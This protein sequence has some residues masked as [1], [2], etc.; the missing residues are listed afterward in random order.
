MSTKHQPVTIKLKGGMGNQMFQF[1]FGQ[2]LKA[3]AKAHG[4]DISL[5]FDISAYID[6][7]KKDTVRPY[8]LPYFGLEADTTH[9]EQAEAVRNPYGPFSRAFRYARHLLQWDNLVQYVPSLLKPPYKS[10]YEGYWQSEKYFNAIEAEIRKL[11]TFKDPLGPEARAL[12]QQISSDEAAISIFYRRT[13]YVGH[14]VFDIGEQA[15]QQRAITRI[16]KLVP[17]GRLYVM[18]DDIAWVKENANLPENSIFVSSPKVKGQKETEVPIPPHE[19]MQ[20][21]MACRHHI[22]PNSTYAWWGAWLNNKPGKIVI[23]PEFWTTKDHD[24]YTDI[25]PGSWIRV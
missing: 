11:F 9:S 4:Y 12:H 23:A 18:S 13:D 22:I 7:I 16:L 1:A 14:G 20:L 21:M 3:S 5:S 25:V 15:Y 6:P 17:H 19:E 10:Y 8:Y 24:Q 2:A